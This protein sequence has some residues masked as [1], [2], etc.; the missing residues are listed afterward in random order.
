MTGD[1]VLDV[2][3]GA[4]LADVGGPDRGGI[5]VWA[6]GTSLTGTPPPLATLAEPET[7]RN[8]G[9]TRSGQGLLLADV[10]GDAVLDVLAGAALANGG[11][12]DAA[13]AIYVWPGGAALAGA[14][15]PDAILSVPGAAAGDQLGHV[16]S[17][18]GIQLHDVTGDGLL[19]VIAGA[20]STDVAG[21]EDVGAVQVWTGGPALT[22]RPAPLASLT[23]PGAVA[24]DALGTASGQALLIE[25]VTGDSVSDLIAGAALADI[26]GASDAGAIYVWAGGVTLAGTPPLRAT[27]AVPG[28]RAGDRLGF[29]AGDG[30]QLADVGGD[31]VLDIVAGAMAAD[32][33]ALSDAGA[34]HVW[35]GGPTLVGAPPPLA[36]CTN[37][38]ASV[39]D[40]LGESSGRGV[41]LAD[42][43]GDARADIVAG[44]VSAD[45]R[46]RDTGAIVVWAGG[47]SLKGRPPAA[48]TLIVPGAS[49]GDRLGASSGQG[50]L[51]AELTGDEVLD[52]LA[53]AA[54]ADV[55][56]PDT[57]AVY[58][59][60]GGG[61]LSGEAPL[62]ATLAVPGERGARLAAAAGQGILLS[63]LTGDGRLE[64]LAV[65]SSARMGKGGI[66]AWSSEAPL[67]GQPPPLAV[68][69]VP[70]AQPGDSLGGPAR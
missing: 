41:Q 25:D 59:W 14:P 49:A 28:A 10:T 32:S 30:I 2:V 38:A 51:L 39:G 35:A 56:A 63:D 67:S 34:I 53:G 20:C 50:I 47:A 4:A 66:L 46:G 31:S 54:A 21:T 43:T 42:V 48:A 12:I 3:A 68:L 58:V 40:R 29:A 18:Q 70:G 65:A 64:I 52:V 24:R 1:A 9:D 16:G 45:I 62:R 61:R 7:A 55:G 36:S 13:G 5:W 11:G 37:A 57:G 19:D 8:L 22:G 23:V 60:E 15:P 44:A 6:G 26:A 17:G 27:L 33:G 69:A